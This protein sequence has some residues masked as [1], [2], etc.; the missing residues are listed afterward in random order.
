MLFSVHLVGP[1]KARVFAGLGFTVANARELETALRSQPHGRGGR[2]IRHV[3]PRRRAS[4][5]V[6]REAGK[7]GPRDSQLRDSINEVNPSASIHG[8]ARPFCAL[9]CTAVISAR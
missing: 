5:A 7:Q 8:S 6:A 2:A 3:A 9:R 1:F 4:H